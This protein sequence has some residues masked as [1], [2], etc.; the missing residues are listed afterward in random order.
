MGSVRSQRSTRCPACA[1]PAPVCLCAELPRVP[2][3]ATI[4]VW[5]HRAE[6]GKSSN[7]GRPAA[8]IVEGARVVVH[9]AIETRASEDDEV[10]ALA[11]GAQ[12]LFPEIGAPVLSASSPPTTLIVPDGTWSQARRLTQRAILAGARL[13]ALPPA[14]SRYGLRRRPRE[15]ALSTY[16]AIAH[17]LAVL[18][19]DGAVARMMPV[20]DAF[21]TRTLAVR[22]R[23]GESR[24][25]P[26]PA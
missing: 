1:L 8:R 14:P 25:R 15:G 12:V 11:P 20:F 22:G 23:R 7:T 17:A 13:V 3:R 5:M 16:E 24:P 21:V 10:T 2:S 4:V 9:G 26:P 6:A 18:E 19:G